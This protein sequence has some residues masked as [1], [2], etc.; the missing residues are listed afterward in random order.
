MKGFIVWLIPLDPTGVQRNKD[1]VAGNRG[2]L[3]GG[4]KA[5]MQPD[6]RLKCVWLFDGRFTGLVP[7]A[8]KGQMLTSFTSSL[9]KAIAR[10]TNVRYEVEFI[11]EE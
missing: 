3:M 2:N 4:G 5:E 7:D 1:F 11:Q 9:D 10:K 6:G 8:A